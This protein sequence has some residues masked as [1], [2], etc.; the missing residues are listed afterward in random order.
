MLQDAAADD[1]AYAKF[2]GGGER[3]NS[4]SLVTEDDAARD[5]SHLRKARQLIDDGLGDAFAQ[6]VIGGIAAGV[7][8]RQ[9]GERINR[10]ADFCLANFAGVTS[11]G[12]FH[13]WNVTGTCIALESF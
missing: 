1:G 5:H 10:L 13:C 12:R 11:R 7:F 2:T 9:D 3:I 6:V 8:K 4:L